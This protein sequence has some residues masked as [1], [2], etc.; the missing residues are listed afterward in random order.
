MPEIRPRAFDAAACAR[1]VEA[2]C[3]PRLARI[4]AARGIAGVDELNTT[5][6]SLASPERLSRVAEAAV[7]LADA[8]AAGEKMLIVAD[9]DAD[10]ATACA[11]GV[12]ALRAMGA[13]VDYLVPNRFEHGYGLT[14]EIAREA[15]ARSPA[16]LITVD[17]GIAAVEGIAE[18]NRLGMRVLV[19]DHHLPG[20]AAPD[21]VCIVNPNQAGCGFPSKSLA[22][23]GVIFYV[24]LALRAELRRRGAFAAKPEPVLGEL[25]DLVALGTVADVVRL[26]ANNRILVAQGLARIRA[27]RACPGIAALF[28][29]AGRDARRAAPY[30]L[31]FSIGPRLN[32]AGRLDDMSV[33][34]ECLLATD[35]GRALSLAQRLDRMNRERREIE[36]E[37]QASA[38]EMLEQ[39]Q[40]GEAYTLA[41]HREDWHAGVVGLLASRLKDRLHR[42]VFA[43]AADNGGRLKGS[44]RSIPG[45]H[46]RDA[47]DLVDKRATGVLE[48]F[49]GHA[50][51]AGCTLAPNTLEAFR[52]A[53]EAVAREL[54]SP[55]DLEQRI[56]TDGELE[57]H[58]MDLDFAQL[59]QGHVWGQGF[60]E[61]RFAGRFEV[62]AQRVVGE[63]HSRLALLYGG[64]RFNAMLFG[65]AEP[66]PAKIEAVYRLDVNEFQ[67]SVSLQLTLEHVG[68]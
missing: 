60:P 55:A 50:A 14:P 3:D 22:G 16:L 29:V 52:R 26:D 31:G 1:F 43:F 9:Y 40:A 67:G 36:G 6:Q 35:S 62:A 5:I 2:G 63:K 11:V 28:S 30:D 24:M 7:L 42:P 65:R 68:G 56:D 34:I 21:A 15:A 8:I 57:A 4:F 38:L 47:L 20:A 33:G 17:N 19:T 64:R 13:K 51:A 23:V 58:E 32:A 37:M 12:K 59:L 41:I 44:G 25:L 46:L 10:G 18:A 49:G 61:P 39:A 54:L 48:R 66:L 53:F 27:G 45:L